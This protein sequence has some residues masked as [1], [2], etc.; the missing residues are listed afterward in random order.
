MIYKVAYLGIPGSYTFT[1]AK[2][3]FGE[4]MELISST[5][6]TELFGKVKREICSFGVI[7]LE[8][9]TT[10]S[11]VQTYDC[12]ISSKLS[13]V[14]EV[15]L[16]IHHNFLVNPSTSLRGDKAEKSLKL[17]KLCYSHP[18][19]ISQCK[20]FLSKYP[21]IKPVFTSD[22][23]SAAKLI[24]ERGKRKEA[25]IAGKDTAKIYGLLLVAANIEKNKS[26]F[27]RFAIIARST[28]KVGNK[29]SLIFSVKHTP[30][31]LFTA[32]S[33]Y[34]EYGFNL[35]K[36]ESR[37]VFGRPWEYIFFLD[38]E[39]EGREGEIK[40]VIAKMRKVAQ[41]VTLLGRYK[42]GEIYET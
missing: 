10:G 41:F 6:L 23:A 42:K 22:T 14:G 7:P 25:A 18:E 4:K 26:N 11:I 8:N 17:I 2:K 40:K 9:S 28:N 24:A 19:A 15:I 3:F 33:P 29:I 36:I 34:A 13:I 21:W 12:L 20:S 39:V 5:S 32:L 27:T 30:G 31:S 1:A 37:P 38:F 16:K 35:T